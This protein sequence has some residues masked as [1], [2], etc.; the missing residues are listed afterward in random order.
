MDKKTQASLDEL[1][2]R[3][4]EL[5]SEVEA[6]RYLLIRDIFNANAALRNHAASIVHSLDML[7]DE[8]PRV[9]PNQRILERVQ[10]HRTEI[11]NIARAHGEDPYQRDDDETPSSR[12][13]KP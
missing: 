11:L 3:V 10:R 2:E 5:E 4:Y 9:P 6:Q 1:F 13:P 12:Q 7:I 8:L